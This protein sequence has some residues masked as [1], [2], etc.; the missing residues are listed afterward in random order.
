MGQ[1]TPF[2]CAMSCGNYK[3]NRGHNLTLMEV[4]NLMGRL[5]KHK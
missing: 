5:D 3:G 4:L 2:N 1:S